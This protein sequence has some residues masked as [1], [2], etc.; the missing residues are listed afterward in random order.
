M[1]EGKES[2]ELNTWIKLAKSKEVGLWN[3]GKEEEEDDDDD[4][5]EDDMVGKNW[6]SVRKRRE[7]GCT[8]S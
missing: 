8:R 6:V 1:E 2:T 3:K 4:M 7:R 5:D